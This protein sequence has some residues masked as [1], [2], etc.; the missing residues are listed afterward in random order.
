[1]RYLIAKILFG[2]PLR[3]QLSRQRAFAKAFNFT[4]FNKID[5]DYLEFGVARGSTMKMAINSS[6]VRGIDGMKFYGVDTFEGFPETIGPETNFKTYRNIVGSRVFTINTLEKKLGFR[7][8][9]DLR[10]LKLNME[11]GDLSTLRDFADLSNLAIVHLDMDYF[12]P[13][14]NAL[15]EIRDGL[16]IGSILMFDNFFFFSGSDLMGERK[17]LSNF[18]SSNPNLIIS[19]YFSYGWHGK[20]F[21]VS[22]IKL[23]N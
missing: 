8:V 16:K 19:E 17:A 3:F 23:V 4:Y 15:M 13:T 1:M 20:A 9:R 18:Q 2:I 21:I 6:R 12:V 11:N 14:Y 7:S 22:N 5:G 10:F